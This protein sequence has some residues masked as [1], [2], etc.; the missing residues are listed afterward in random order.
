MNIVYIHSSYNPND[1]IG[2]WFQVTRQWIR[3]NGGDAFFAIKYT[4]RQVQ[5]DDIQVGNS[6]SCGIHARMFD[7]FWLQDCFSYLATR[8]FLR[9]LDEIKPDI[10]HCHVVND[11]FM[12]LG[13]FCNYVNKRGIKVVWTF[14]DAR[15]LTGACACPCYA[16][17]DQWKTECRRCPKEKRFIAPRHEWMN[18]VSLVH[19]YRKKHIGSIQDLTIV[20]PSQWMKSLVDQS[21]LRDKKCVVINNGINLS[22]FHPVPST[23]KEE[24]A[25]P[26]DKKWL[27][28]VANPI[29]QMKGRDYLLRLVDEL[30]DEYYMILV[31]CLPKDVEA[32]KGRCNVL[33]FPRVAR[34]RLVQ[35]YSVAD[36]FINPTLADNFPTVNLECQACGTPVVAFN[37]DGTRETVDP[38]SGVVVERANYDALKKAILDFHFEGVEK[39]CVCF[40]RQYNQEHTVQQYIQLYRSL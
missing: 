33:A 14:H 34:E 23:I 17:C 38:N 20:T 1:L 32:L 15:V 35:F 16:E 39:K 21:Y 4:H 29:W 27:L 26:A 12:H 37:S 36:L 10:I 2:N 3:D 28:S 6:L 8:K 31:G 30:P 19:K 13:L 40:A 24:Y 7:R 9:R 18:G 25:I 5:P 11:C 22:V